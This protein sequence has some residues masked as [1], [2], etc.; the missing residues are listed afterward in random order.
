MSLPSGKPFVYSGPLSF[1]DSNFQSY[2]HS[3]QVDILKPLNSGEDFKAS[4]LE[5][6][7]E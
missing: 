3:I 6:I 4:I 7:Y 5:I 2:K 1:I